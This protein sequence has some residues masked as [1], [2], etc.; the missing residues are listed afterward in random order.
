MNLFSIICILINMHRTYAQTC[1][2]SKYFP[3]SCID[4]LKSGMKQ[5]GIYQIAGAN[6]ET[7]NVFCDFT[8]EHG[9]AWT[10]V[11]S[12]S[13]ANAKIRAFR[14]NAFPQNTPLNEMSPN[15]TVYRMSKEQMS[16]IKTKSTHWRATCSFDQF[17]IDYRDYMRGKFEDV[18]I[19]TLYDHW[20]CYKVEYINIRGIAGHGTVALF[21]SSGIP[22][23]TESRQKIH[24]CDFKGHVGEKNTEKN[25]GY[26]GRTNSAF[27][28]T[29]GPTA[30]TQYWF[31]SYL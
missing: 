24:K 20:G 11:M 9:S 5:N 10:L 14:S 19:T 1:G 21:Q 27:R 16:F 30:T 17:G 28:C 31:G 29:A 4:I 26:Y 23:H 8:T 15:W 3:N 13:F 18:D 12:W 25:F 6:G 2:G 22:F 7:W